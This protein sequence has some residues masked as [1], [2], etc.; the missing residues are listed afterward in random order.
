M[1]RVVEERSAIE[2]AFDKRIYHNNH[3]TSK[4]IPI[5]CLHLQVIVRKKKKT[6][7]CPSIKSNVCTCVPH[8]SICH[9]ASERA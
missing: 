1:P 4:P 7:P 3:K 6:P 5:P 8:S 9:S 2:Y